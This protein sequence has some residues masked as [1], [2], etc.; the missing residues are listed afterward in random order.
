[1]RIKGDVILKNELSC[2]REIIILVS[3]H[4]HHVLDPVLKKYFRDYLARGLKVTSDA[5]HLSRNSHWWT[6]SSLREQPSTVAVQ[7]AALSGPRTVDVVPGPAASNARAPGAPTWAFNRHRG[8]PHTCADG[9]CDPVTSSSG[10]TP[11]YAGPPSFYPG[12]ESLP[13]GLPGP[14]SGIGTLIGSW[15]SLRQSQ[16]PPCTSSVLLRR[17]CRRWIELN[18]L[19]LD[20]M[21]KVAVDHMSILMRFSIWNDLSFRKDAF[22]AKNQMI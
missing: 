11:D 6:P 2:V 15:P 3:C 12:V 17:P 9:C 22:G 14:G 21:R 5:E 7:A 4:S 19:F 1:M 20:L 8:W 18:R 13:Y 16:I 10:T